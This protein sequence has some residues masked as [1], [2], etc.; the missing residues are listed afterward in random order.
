MAIE[1]VDLPI[2]SM[3]ISYTCVSLPE[4]THDKWDH[5]MSIIDHGS[6]PI[7]TT[8]PKEAHDTHPNFW[9]TSPLSEFD[10]ASP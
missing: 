7:F 9:S 10:N 5:R 2:D 8:I 3:M 4:G 1:I 6:D